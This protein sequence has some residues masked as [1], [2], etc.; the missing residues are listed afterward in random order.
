MNNPSY[1][2]GF[3]QIAVEQLYFSLRIFSN[4]HWKITK[5]RKGQQKTAYR[6]GGKLVKQIYCLLER[7][8]NTTDLLPAGQL[9]ISSLKPIDRCR[10]HDLVNS[11]GILLYQMTT[12]MLRLT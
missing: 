10:H 12:D 9:H 4:V 5:T 1:V 8:S 3:F 11:Y 2:F 6:E 7:A